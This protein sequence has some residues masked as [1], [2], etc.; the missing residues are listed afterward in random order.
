M[1]I[2]HSPRSA[3]FINS[4]LGR[5]AEWRD[6]RI[7]AAE[8]EKKRQALRLAASVR[9]A[10]VA[11]RRADLAR[12]K[13]ERLARLLQER[14]SR[15]WLV[16]HNRRD[17]HQ[18][19][20]EEQASLVMQSCVRGF[21]GRYKVRVL[22][23]RARRSDAATR[24]QGW[25]LRQLAFKRRREAEEAK[26]VAAKER[27]LAKLSATLDK[28]LS[29]RGDAVFGAAG[30]GSDSD[31]DNDGYSSDGFE[32]DADG[33]SSAAEVGEEPEAGTPRP[34]SGAGESEPGY[35]LV[36]T[37]NDGPPLKIPVLSPR[38]EVLAQ[39][40]PF[41]LPGAFDGDKYRP[42]KTRPIPRS[43]FEPPN[44]RAAKAAQEAA[45]W[46]AK[47]RGAVARSR[48]KKFE[49]YA[50][51]VDMPFFPLGAPLFAGQLLT[52]EEEVIAERE[53]Q[54]VAEN[55]HRE[56]S[57]DLGPNL[58]LASASGDWD[59]SPPKEAGGEYGTGGMVVAMKS[60]RSR[61]RTSRTTRSSPRSRRRGGSPRRTTTT[62]HQRRSARRNRRSEAA[63]AGSGSAA[64]ATTATDEDPAL[65]AWDSTGGGRYVRPDDEMPL[66]SNV[67]PATPQQR[68]GDEAALA[69]AGHGRD[70]G[71]IWNSHDRVGEMDR[72]HTR[73]GAGTHRATSRGPAIGG[74][75]TRPRTSPAERLGSTG[76]PESLI[77]LPR[78]IPP[79]MANKRSTEGDDS[80][81]A[82]RTREYQANTILSYA[83]DQRLDSTRPKARG[84]R[85]GGPVPPP[86]FN[87]PKAP[88]PSSR[89]RAAPRRQ[90]GREVRKARHSDG[91]GSAGA[92][93]ESSSGIASPRPAAND[94]EAAA[95]STPGVAP[96][97]PMSPVTANGERA[98]ARD[99]T[100]TAGPTAETPMPDHGGGTGS[101]AAFPPVAAT[102]NS[103]DD[104][105]DA[106]D[107]GLPPR[108]P[109]E[110][111]GGYN[112]KVAE[113]HPGTAVAPYGGVPEG[114]TVDARVSITSVGDE[115]GSAAG[116]SQQSVISTAEW[117]CGACGFANSVD[118]DVC[119]LCELARK[120]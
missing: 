9:R 48:R 85:V 16:H 43:V 97:P 80:R 7:S 55:V 27:E 19:V 4:Y 12:A 94:G 33:G 91:S 93:S 3:S 20:L 25:W 56:P 67:L 53:A 68:S 86:A 113:A 114:F 99:A 2:G 14:E 81:V 61:L 98:Q 32:E 51:G 29:G 92:A 1:T 5:E 39:P 23:E 62:A 41:L 66:Y 101:D 50:A 117:E 96:T 37:D 28:Q 31:G 49:R 60:S 111:K 112:S 63:T 13:Q 30:T 84:P 104:T 76:E 18:R 102:D 64:S 120:A 47:R 44:G 115:G 10:E 24:L 46:A 59:N 21:Q 105:H 15:R 108:G 88:P 40:N 75:T 103:H 100:G 77:L 38:M 110:S 119:T 35:T 72:P 79:Q 82:A 109:S 8:N 116:I 42:F 83:H 45:D 26:D 36:F 57:R 90:R 106:R 17:P 87:A 107:R 95:R 52:P 69:T 74:S 89:R 118:V 65:A 54:N 70:S 58:P 73:A 11:R 71:H 22:R 78:Y 34:A 6:T